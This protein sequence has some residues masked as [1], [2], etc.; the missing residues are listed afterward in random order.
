MVTYQ[1]NLDARHRC[2]ALFN[3]KLRKIALLEDP[4]SYSEHPYL[5]IFHYNNSGRDMI[6]RVLPLLV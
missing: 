6:S 4:G 3:N 1:N 5:G 2:L